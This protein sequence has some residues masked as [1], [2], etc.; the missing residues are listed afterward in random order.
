RVPLF[1]VLHAKEVTERIPLPLLFMIRRLLARSGRIICVSRFTA[2]AARARFGLPAE[3]V[4]VI[5]PGVDPAIYHPAP[6]APGF[7]ARYGLGH[8]PVILT[9]ARV[10]AR[11]G[12]DVVV[13]AL[14]AVLARHPEAVYVVCGKPFEPF[15]S[16]LKALVSG[17]GL[18]GHVRFTGHVP[19]ADVADMYRACDVCVMPSRILARKGDTE[20]FGITFIEAG[21]CAK[22]VIG[23]RE[24]GVVDA[25]VDG[26]TGLLVDPS[27]PAAVAGALNRILDDPALAESM[28]EA[29]RRRVEEAFTWDRIA[30]RYLA[31]L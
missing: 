1:T 13:R 30:R 12:H 11:K 31:L 20:G 23:G 5:H 24:A 4:T 6:P 15:A 8:G 16:R 19:A 17:M 2:D 9:M 7:R 27:D 21:A 10:I 22:P 25:I 14:P 28:G 26:D 3:K 29:G 18:E